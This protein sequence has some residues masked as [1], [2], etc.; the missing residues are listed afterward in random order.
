MEVEFLNM[1]SSLPKNFRGLLPFFLLLFLPEGILRAAPAPLAIDAAVQGSLAALNK[2]NYASA[3]DI[4]APALQA[5]PQ[6]PEILNLQG[7]IL[8]KQKN[9]AAAQRY[10]EQALQA[11]P[12][13]FPAR[14]NIGALMALQEQWDPAITYY[15]K[16]LLEQPNNELVEYK[17]L[18]LL[19]HQDADPKLQAKLFA[20]N[21][22]TNT[23]AW[24]YATAARCYKKGDPKEAAKYLEVAKNIYGDKTAIFQE[25]LDESGLNE[26]K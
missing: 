10:Y 4:L 26:R 2:K 16:L 19:L 5:R 13:F 22:P 3:L 6:D 18:L 24:Y 1:L 23:P 7:A 8:T 25:E 21:L 17:L 14:Y 9:Y 20:T 15:H 11:S 12:D